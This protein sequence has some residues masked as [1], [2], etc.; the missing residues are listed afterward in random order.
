[1]ITVLNRSI[2]IGSLWTAV[3]IGV[4]ADVGARRVEDPT[5]DHKVGAAED[6]RDSMPAQAV[7]AAAVLGLV[8]ASVLVLLGKRAGG[9]VLV[10]ATMLEVAA[11]GLGEPTW[12]SAARE[13]AS[14]AA[15][16][17]TGIVIGVLGASHPRP[18][19]VG[20]GEARQGNHETKHGAKR[21][22]V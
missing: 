19:W 9:Y 12:P 6:Q 7:G 22:P 14:E 13:C 3:V 4:V 17:I 2:L 21:A 16:I 11:V 8:A 5:A 1:M 15:M 10:S 20:G 18:A